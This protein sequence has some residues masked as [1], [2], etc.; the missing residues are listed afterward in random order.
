M[1]PEPPKKGKG[2]K[3]GPNRRGEKFDMGRLAKLRGSQKERDAREKRRSAVGKGAGVNAKIAAYERA[4]R[5]KEAAAAKRRTKEG[6]EGKPERPERKELPGIAGMSHRQIKR[7]MKKPRKHGLPRMIREE[8]STLNAAGGGQI[9][10]R[11]GLTLR[12]KPGL[13][14]ADGHVKRHPIY[15]L[16]YEYP[17]LFGRRKTMEVMIGSDGRVIG[18]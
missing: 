4:Q 6:A 1:S 2:R 17:S 18:S 9:M 14:A 16:T 11:E 15:T 8:M 5:E 3:K 13:K 12:L 10:L 7:V